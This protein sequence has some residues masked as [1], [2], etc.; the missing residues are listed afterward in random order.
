M[1]RKLWA[2]ALAG[3]LACAPASWAQSTYAVAP[4]APK[5]AAKPAAKPAAP[6]A[7]P[8]AAAPQAKP[9]TAERIITVH[10]TGKAPQKCRVLRCWTQRDGG[11][12][13]EVEDVATGEKMTILQESAGAKK[14]LAQ[15]FRWGKSGTAPAGAPVAPVATASAPAP[16]P[17]LAGRLLSSKPAAGARP[18]N[19]RESWGKVE[20]WTAADSERASAM[21]AAAARSG[22]PARP[23]AAKSASDPLM[24]PEKYAAAPAKAEPAKVE[25]A[26]AEVV[27][28][29]GAV[30]P[31]PLPPPAITSE[32]AADCKT[33][34]KP[35][36]ARKSLLGML[37]GSGEG[38]VVS[39]P[40]EPKVPRRLGSGSVAAVESPQMQREM[41]MMM[42]AGPDGE[43][44]LVPAGE[45]KGAR[46]L[47][48]D[49]T[50][51]NAFS[52]PM[53]VRQPQ[54]APA[55]VPMPPMMMPGGGVM[56]AGMSMAPSLP[57]GAT[58][59]PEMQHPAMV[60]MAPTA[61][62]VSAEQEQAVHTARLVQML[63]D[64]QLPSEREMA[65]DGLSRANWKA[66]PAVV[67]ALTHHAKSDPAPMVRAGCVQALAKM[68]ANTM[69]VVQAVSACKQDADPRVRQAAEQALEV[70]MAVK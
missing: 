8:K 49:V 3:A 11:T 54:P 22:A 30:K 12:V 23:V 33:E 46:V 6:R 7:A 18:A 5:A 53:A 52:G 44:M 70:L 37:R 55:H 66:E 41:N 39:A 16:R 21:A 51:P 2:G 32:A 31:A 50:G 29:G 35:A 38:K 1:V 59:Q 64:G 34:C 19:P 69:P 26:K 9:A 28:A 60:A 14:A 63:R 27:K 17:S 40:A 20:R 43:P 10:E 13:C 47:A 25:P 4:V 58:M 61:P 24:Q 45:V 36:P 42:V 48:V 65:A 68:R 62:H 67:Q 56:M 57:P 15:I